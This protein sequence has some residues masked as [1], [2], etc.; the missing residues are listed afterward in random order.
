MTELAADI[1]STLLNGLEEYS[2]LHNI[3][4]ADLVALIKDSTFELLP[5]NQLMIDFGADG[6][7]DALLGKGS[8][9]QDLTRVA[10]G[11]PNAEVWVTENGDMLPIGLYLE[12]L[13][14]AS[15]P[16]KQLEFISTPV[17]QQEE[18]ALPSA[19]S[20]ATIIDHEDDF[21][22]APAPASSFGATNTQDRP[23]AEKPIIEQANNFQGEMQPPGISQL[24]AGTFS[25][26]AKPVT[27]PIAALSQGVRNINEWRSTRHDRYFG[28]AQSIASKLTENLNNFSANHMT[29]LKADLQATEFWDQ[30]TTIKFEEMLE[31]V[32]VK[33]E[34]YLLQDQLAE[35][36]A[37]ARKAIRLAEDQPEKAENF[38]KDLD[39]SFESIEVA[40]AKVPFEIKGGVVRQDF[41]EAASGFRD[42]FRQLL[43]KL[44][45]KILKNVTNEAVPSVTPMMDLS[46]EH[47][48]PRPNI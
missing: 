46:L 15:S 23:H 20:V 28:E 39:K 40:G 7:P 42:F 6:N 30:A 14:L 19:E 41:S 34:W 45:K 24:I 13:E 26:L 8:F 5:P 21:L 18:P 12:P 29:E 31:N 16:I 43:A 25:L 48:T 33:R 35:F 4:L 36:N 38:Y 10:I 27:S 44:T 47:P 9:L 3:L 11:N 2:K 17:S 32:Q 1:K 22:S 37:S